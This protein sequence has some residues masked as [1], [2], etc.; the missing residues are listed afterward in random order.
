VRSLR[1]LWAKWSV[2]VGATI[3]LTVLSYVFCV[4]NIDRFKLPAQESSAVGRLRDIVLLQKDFR[5]RHGCFASE[6]DQLPDVVS[7]DHSYTYAILS[8]E[9]DEKGCVTRFIVAASPVLTTKGSRFF[10]ID[11]SE[12]IRYERSHP[13]DANSPLLR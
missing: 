12:T 5:T 10:S 8:E 4:P 2:G 6:L 11:E 9:K 1:S 3:G 13:V 7:I